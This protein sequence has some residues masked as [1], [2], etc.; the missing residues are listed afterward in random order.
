MRRR[1]K[2]WAMLTQDTNILVSVY[3][4]KVE[5]DASAL[6]WNSPKMHVVRATLTFDDGAKLDGRPAARRR[7][8]RKGGRRG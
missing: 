2:A 6:C 1:V 7:K 5:A 4:S 8:G 3:Q